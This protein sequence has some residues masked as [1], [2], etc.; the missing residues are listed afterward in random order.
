MGGAIAPVSVVIPCYNAASTVH[1]ALVSVVSQSVKPREVIVVDDGSTDATVDVVL[2]FAAAYSE[3]SV[4]FRV[5]PLRGNCGPGHARNV[6][7]EHATQPYIAFL[8][9]DDAWH[10]SKIAV[11]WRWMAY[12]SEA[13][14]TGTL[15]WRVKH[16]AVPRLGSD[17]PVCVPQCVGQPVRVLPRNLL[18]FNKFQTTTVMI[19]R[20]LPFRFVESMRYSEDYHLW[21]RIVLAGY[22]AYLLPL[23]LAYVFKTPFSWG[24]S[25]HLWSM[26][27]G[28][29]EAYWRLWKEQ[30]ISTPILSICTLWSLSKF[31]RRVIIRAWKSTLGEHP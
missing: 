9:S 1:R 19:R 16:H 17:P 15:S 21:L 29:L 10:P 11:Q 14:L 3:T 25:S 26:E 23:R 4:S 5:I 31:L 8:D 27:R 7:W 28:E 24:L 30:M 13:A 12:H 22:C 6:G 18:L 2:R 20:D